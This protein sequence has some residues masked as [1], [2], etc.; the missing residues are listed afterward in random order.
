VPARTGAGGAGPQTGIRDDDG[1]DAWTAARMPDPARVVR[2]TEGRP[3][4]ERPCRP[5][6]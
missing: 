4:E 6:P 5:Y 1:R 3:S 2:V